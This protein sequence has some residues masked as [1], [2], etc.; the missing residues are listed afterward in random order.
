MPRAKVTLSRESV[1]IAV[2][3]VEAGGEGAA[4]LV[5]EV[6]TQIEEADFFYGLVRGHDVAEIP[7][8]SRVGSAPPLHAVIGARKPHVRAPGRGWK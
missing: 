5:E 3:T 1:S 8:P 2:L 6:A 7:E 4:V